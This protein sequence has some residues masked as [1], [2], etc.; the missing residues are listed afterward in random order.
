MTQKGFGEKILQKV[1]TNKKKN[2]ETYT[3]DIV[4]NDITVTTEEV[5]TSYGE[6]FKPTQE[7]IKDGLSK[8]QKNIMCFMNFLDIL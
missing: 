6:S 1:P 4:G 2:N 8:F 5:C 3:F 7:F